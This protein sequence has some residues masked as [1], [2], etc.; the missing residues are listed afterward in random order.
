MGEYLGPRPR[1]SK[2]GVSSKNCDLHA[3][4]DL[5]ED[6]K[7]YKRNREICRNS[8]KQKVKAADPLIGSVRR[9]CREYQ[10]RSLKI[11]GTVLFCA[12]LINGLVVHATVRR[13]LPERKRCLCD[14]G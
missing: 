5:K 12:T 7:R 11:I 13:R 8:R 6:R 3:P 9:Q 10:A 14:F 4:I 1:V 2:M